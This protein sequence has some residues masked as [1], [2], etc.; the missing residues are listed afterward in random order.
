[1][2][3]KRA[4]STGTTYTADQWNAFIAVLHQAGVTRMIG[5][6]NVDRVRSA[7]ASSG[8]DLSG[9]NLADFYGRSL[10]DL[11][12]ALA[13]KGTIPS[14]SVVPDVT[15]IVNAV[16]GGVGGLLVGGGLLV[17][18]AVLGWSGVKDLLGD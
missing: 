7:A 6:E 2:T 17:V 10:S 12:D 1:V 5:P 11:R 9:V 16:M 8:I 18:V 13:A 14:A 3:D 4:P 15:G